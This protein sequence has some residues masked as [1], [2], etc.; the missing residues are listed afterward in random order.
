[1]IPIYQRTGTVRGEN[2][3][4]FQACLASVL[5]LRLVDVPNFYEGVGNGKLLPDVNRQMM[6]SWLRGR[7]LAY[8]EFGL[9]MTIHEVL[10]QMGDTVRDNVYLLTGRTETWHIHTV[11]ARSDRVIHDPAT[12]P[13]HHNLIGPCHDGYVR[14]GLFLWKL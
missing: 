11:L 14:V 4:C 7:G 13:G 9:P 8:C 2:G 1:M 6:T 3:D 5:N 10:C 12:S